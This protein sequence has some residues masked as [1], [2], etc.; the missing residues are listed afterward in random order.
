MKQQ[1]PVIAGITDPL[2]SWDACDAPQKPYPPAKLAY[3]EEDGV[4][5]L[6]YSKLSMLHTCPRKFFLKNIEAQGSH[7]PN[8]HLAYGHAYGA[9]VQTYL[10][11]ASM[12][13]SPKGLERALKYACCMAFASW[14][15]YDIDE[16]LEASNKSFNTVIRALR[17][18]ALDAAQ[19]LEDYTI[20]MFTDKHGKEKAA[21][22]LLVYVELTEGY[23]YQMHIDCVLQHKQ[24][25]QLAVVEIKT[26]SRPFERSDYQ[27]SAQ[28]M[29][30][31]VALQAAFGLD[32]VQ[33][34]TIYICHNSKECDTTIFVFERGLD[35]GMEWAATTLLDVQAIE[36]YKAQEFWPRRGENCKAFNRT[37]E[38][39]GT[40]HM[41]QYRTQQEGSY[42]KLG[43]DAADILVS[44]EQILAL[45]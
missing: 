32:Q 35:I 24:T 12:D 26:G 10:H 2:A 44:S 42:S 39:F 18:F 15:M 17:I 3:I 7:N 37:C 45:L 31:C 13:S 14:D 8:I 38:F 29:G 6:S 41:Q 11:Y 1:Q 28:S 4:L 16:V 30:Y 43:K 33:H 25:K 23:S 22:E 20:F 40:C 19:L 34:T 5:G 36:T 21:N 9:G 27:N